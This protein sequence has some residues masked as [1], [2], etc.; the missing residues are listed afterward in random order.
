[1]LFRS[2][3]LAGALDTR[4]EKLSHYELGD[5][6]VM[7][8]ENHVHSAISIM[9]LTSFLFFL[10]VTIPIITILNLIGWWFHV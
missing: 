7:L 1:M 3:A 2:A 10:L 5:G 6:D 9:K 4:F 8:N